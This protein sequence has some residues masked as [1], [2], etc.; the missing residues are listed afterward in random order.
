M[1]FDPNQYTEEE[2]KIIIKSQI[3]GWLIES[4]CW[5]VPDNNGIQ[6]CEWCNLEKRL[7]DKA[8]IDYPLCK[9]NPIITALL[10]QEKNYEEET[11]TR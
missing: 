10:I 8:D 11:T 2:K 7:M 6:M 5:G 4:H 1:Y 3:G 9:E